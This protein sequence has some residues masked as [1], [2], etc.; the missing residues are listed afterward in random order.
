MLTSLL[1]RF[2]WSGEMLGVGLFDQLAHEFP[3]LGDDFRTMRRMEEVNVAMWLPLAVAHG[4]S[5]AD[6]QPRWEARGR[7][8]G[9]AIGRLGLPSLLIPAAYGIPV[10]L[11]SYRLLQALLPDH[12]AIYTL[13]YQEHERAIQDW[14]QRIR[15]QQPHAIESVTSYLELHT[16]GPD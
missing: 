4:I 8:I 2:A 15:R 3:A 5:P 9:M 13:T 1:I 10:V 6:R 14:A 11:V 12:E 7:A 16:P